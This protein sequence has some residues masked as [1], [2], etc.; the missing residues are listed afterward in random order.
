MKPIWII[1]RRELGVFFD[2]LMAYI[3]IILFLTV[4]GLLTWLFGN[5]IFMSG[6]ANLAVFFFWAYWTLF[7]FIPAITMRLIAEEKRSGTIELLLTKPVTDWQFVSGKFLSALILVA[8]ALGLTLPYYFTVWKLGPIDH[9]SVL[10]GYLGLLLMSGAYISIG[11]IASALTN[12]QIVAFLVTLFIGIFFHLL[13]GLL[14][15]GFPGIVGRI[16]NYMSM[17]THYESVSRGV[18]DT[19]D[20]IYF[21]SFMIIG[22]VISEVILAKRNIADK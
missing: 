3:L 22:L 12:N 14:A 16:L 10:T 9:G 11:I 20:I 17:Q 21:F 18:L 15:S 5:D 19:K 7:L 13:F 4:T 8:I 6:Q 2:S 1:A